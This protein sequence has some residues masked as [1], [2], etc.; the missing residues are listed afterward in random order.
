MDVMLPPEAASFLQLIG[1]PWPN[2]SVDEIGLDSEAWR[3]VLAGILPAGVLSDE[4]VRTAGQVF[5][6]EAADAMADTWHGVAEDLGKAAAA[7]SHL[8]A[9]LDNTAWLATAV[10]AGVGAAAV[11]ALVRVSRALLMG[12]PVGVAEASSEMYRARAVIGK[13]ER[14]GAEGAARELAPKLRGKVDEMLQILR[15]RGGRGPGGRPALA[16]ADGLPGRGAAVEADSHMTMMSRGW[17]GGG[18]DKARTEAEEHV[19]AQAADAEFKADGLE[20]LADL[21]KETGDQHIVESRLG[22]AQEHWANEERL[23]AEAAQERQRNLKN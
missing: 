13:L 5:S 7:V 19:G 10:K 1:V 23:R 16:T 21:E 2:V 8:P 4:V 12:G 3:T 15:E 18:S 22:P 14:D 6:G 11:V 9:V 20:R 17:F